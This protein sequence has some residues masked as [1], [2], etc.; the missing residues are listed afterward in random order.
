MA[1]SDAA[2][3]AQLVAE[4]AQLGYLVEH[5]HALPVVVDDHATGDA[6]AQVL[7]EIETP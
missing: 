7:A 4:C 6:H 5:A 1:I 2:N 3:N